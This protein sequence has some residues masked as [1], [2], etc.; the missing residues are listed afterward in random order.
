MNLFKQE[1]DCIAYLYFGEKKTLDDSEERDSNA[2]KDHQGR[3]VAVVLATD[4]SGPV[5]GGTEGETWE[6]KE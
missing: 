3:S 5:Q 4:A 6:M 1:N 2:G